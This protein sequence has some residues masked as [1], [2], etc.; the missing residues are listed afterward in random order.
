MRR[1]RPLRLPLIGI[2]A[3]SLFGATSTLAKTPE[4]VRGVVKSAKEAVLSADL[5][6]RVLETPVM[7][8]DSF[9]KDDTLL[10][11]DC[12]I[13]Q[14]EARA[15]NAAYTASVSTHRNNLDLQQYGAVGEF[16]V[17]MSKAEM[18]R[19]LAQ[20]EAIKARTKDC[21][22]R[23]PFDGK[24]AD[25]AINAYETPGPH[26]PLLKIVSSDSHEI[27]L[28]VPSS[29]LAWLRLD[30]SLEFVVDE[31]GVTHEATVKRL[32]AEVD[33][34]SKTVPVTANFK[35]SPDAVLPG[36]SG[37]AYFKGNAQ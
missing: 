13:Q 15:A 12:E 24:V 2:L 26:Q 32:G 8:G 28:I 37:T 9:S 14:A 35:A 17:N 21:E 29:W 7:Q 19:A 30:S 20:A 23:A 10:K 27:H 31:T 22:L 18:Q 6:A 4:P 34:V 25:L 33:A 1:T 3:F 5:N 36:M 11:F 16:E